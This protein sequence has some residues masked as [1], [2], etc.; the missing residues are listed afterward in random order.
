MLSGRK[1]GAD[2]LVPSVMLVTGLF[3]TGFS[4]VSTPRPNVHLAQATPP[5]Q[6]T[7]APATND[8]PAESKPGGTRPTTPAPQPA[9]PDA[10]AQREGAKPALPP[11]PPEKIAPPMEKK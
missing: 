9:R 4:V 3:L 7:P 8:K 6:G 1:R 5:L 11:A 10:Q 2:F